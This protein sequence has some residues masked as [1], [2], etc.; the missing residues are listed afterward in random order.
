MTMW[1]HSESSMRHSVV[2]N[3]D[4]FV[5]LKRTDSFYPDSYSSLIISQA[6]IRNN[7]LFIAPRDGSLSL[8]LEE[9]CRDAFGYFLIPQATLSTA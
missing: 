7:N 3:A 5:K 2:F 4:T 8:H 9:I 6:I 1:F